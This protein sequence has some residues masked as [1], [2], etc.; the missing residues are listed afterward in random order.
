MKIRFLLLLV[1]NTW[2]FTYLRAQNADTS[3][4]VDELVVQGVKEQYSNGIKIHNFESK[5]LKTFS[6]LGL[7]DL[8][9]GSTTIYTRHDASGLATILLRGMTPDHTGVFVDGINLN[10]LTLGQANLF[11]VP[12]FFFDEASIQYGGSSTLYGTD[13]IAGSIHLTSKPTWKKGFSCTAEQQLASYNSYYSGIK[14][15]QVYQKFQYSGKLFYTQ[16]K[17]NFKFTSPD[18]DFEKNE[19]PVIRQKNNEYKQ[20]GMLQEIYFRPTTRTIS[21]IKYMYINRW[22]QVQPRMSATLS[23]NF[24]DMLNIKHCLIGGVSHQ[25]YNNNIFKTRLA[26]VNDYQNH[27]SISIIA[28]QRVISFIEYEHHIGKRVQLSSGINSKIIK[29]NVHAYTNQSPEIQTDFF[30]STVNRLIPGITTSINMRSPWVDNKHLAYYPA[31]NI[32]NKTRISEFILL[33]SGVSVSRNYNA[34]TFN[35]TRWEKLGNPNLKHEY[36]VNA[37]YNGK[38]NV[39]HNV[40]SS[41]FEWSFYAIVLKDMINWI[42]VDMDI[43]SATKYEIGDWVPVN[44]K[45][46]ISKGFEIL[47]TNTYKFPGVEASLLCS[48]NYN[49]VKAIEQYNSRQHVLG[50]QLPYRP[51]HMARAQIQCSTKK[52]NYQVEC[53]YTGKRINDDQLQWLQPYILV[54]TSVNYSLKKAFTLG[55]GINNLF[56]I[57]Y[58]NSQHY[59]MPGLNAFVKLQYSFNNHK[60]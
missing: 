57:E 50:K 60:N 44:D 43:A 46:V 5:Q 32:S 24:T 59:A 40:W 53:N 13:A 3:I 20:F 9:S 55:T 37:D 15:K 30:I 27:D 11:D 12:L 25:T 6:T 42:P 52:L 2:L 23:E 31:I 29:P 58:Q 19:F 54:N 18:K 21:Y 47:L 51:Y 7:N 17:N 1:C 35:D 34:P 45:K 16:S 33:F 39:Q 48:Y 26:W 49:N 10:S 56:N 22:N 38:I 28:T 14:I 41:F 8:I 4:L 36:S